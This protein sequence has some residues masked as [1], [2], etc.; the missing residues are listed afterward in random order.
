MVALILF[1]VFILTVLVMFLI[2]SWLTSPQRLMKKRLAAVWDEPG[3]EAM[4]STGTSDRRQRIRTI[5]SGKENSIWSILLGADYLQRKQLELF[6]AGLPFKAEELLMAKLLTA[7]LGFIIGYLLLGQLMMGVVLGIL[8]FIMPQMWVSYN[9]AH[10]I[11]TIDDQL[12]DAILLMAG[13]LRSGHSFLQALDLVSRET[14]PPL[15]EEFQRV[16][17]ENRIGLRLED[18]LNNLTDR[19]ESREI[20]L[21]VAGVLVQREVGGNLAEVLDNIATTIEKRVKM[22]AKLRALTAQGRMSAWVIS[23]LP[24]VLAFFIFTL[25]PQYGGLLVNEPLGRI[26]LIGGVIMLVIGI[27]LVRRVVDIDV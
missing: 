3:S 13:S 21:M 27:L 23:L 17:H 20:E 19:T 14:F 10:R 16:L 25:N 15:S 2:L 5:A 12:L 6:K 18:A 4:M 24:F 22:Q 7:V 26:M 8:G 9:K 11:R 1:S